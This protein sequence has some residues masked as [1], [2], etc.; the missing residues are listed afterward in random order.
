MDGG[1]HGMSFHPAVEIAFK[2]VKGK[3]WVRAG[4]GGLKE[5]SKSPVEYYKLHQPLSWKLPVHERG[6]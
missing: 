2:D 4:R 1:Y 6:K 5:L 3:N